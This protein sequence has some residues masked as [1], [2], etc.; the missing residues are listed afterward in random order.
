MSYSSP[1]K[2]GFPFSG[3]ISVLPGYETL[4]QSHVFLGWTNPTGD[5]RQVFLFRAEKNHSIFLDP[6]K[7]NNHWVEKRLKIFLS[8]LLF[9]FTLL[10]TYLFYSLFIYSNSL[11]EIIAWNKSLGLPIHLSYG[12]V[13]GVK[14]STGPKPPGV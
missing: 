13:E 3:G 7:K 2:I 9:F 12:W 1:S 14:L 8:L 5:F 6:K 10:F 4:S 11:E